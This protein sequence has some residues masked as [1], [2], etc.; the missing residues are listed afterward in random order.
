MVQED[1]HKIS[2]HTKSHNTMYGIVNLE[3]ITNV[4]PSG[5]ITHDTNPPL[6]NISYYSL[7]IKKKKNGKTKT[8]S[9]CQ[10]NWMHRA[11]NLCHNKGNDHLSMHTGYD[12]HSCTNFPFY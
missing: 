12:N 11:L 7:K 8:P 4:T 1:L 5:V 6:T 10:R 3:G 9:R 2:V